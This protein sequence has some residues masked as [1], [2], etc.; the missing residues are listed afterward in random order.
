M[1]LCFLIAVSWGF[2]NT[3]LA[4]T[5]TSTAAGL[6]ATASQLVEGVSEMVRLLGS[7]Q[8]SKLATYLFTAASGAC[9]A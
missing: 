7:S 5:L 6:F 4:A 3:G 9:Q 2:I 1:F 8:Y